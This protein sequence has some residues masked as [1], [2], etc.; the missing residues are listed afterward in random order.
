MAEQGGSAAA[1]QGDPGATDEGAG[2]GAEQG[3]GL[4]L[5]DLSGA[6]EELRPY[7]EQELK[8]YDGNVT[9]KFQEHADFRKR[10]EPYADVDFGDVQADELGELLQFRQVLQDPEQLQEWLGAVNE[11]LGLTPSSP[12]EWYALGEQNG[13]I[14]GEGNM[15]EPDE[16]PQW[17]QQLMDRVEALDGGFKQFQGQAEQQQTAAQQAEEFR[18]RLGELQIPEEDRAAVIQEARLFLEGEDPIGEA[19]QHVQTLRGTAEGDRV[20]QRLERNGDTEG[21]L[22]QGQVNSA[23]EQMQFGDPNLKA[24]ALARMKQS[25]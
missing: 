17:A 22:P 2:Q 16:M 1:A 3:V 25:P 19:W 15:E 5:Y 8:K 9:K 7:L 4:G 14:D 10:F 23:A 13:W 21:A 11:Q 6:P 20:E 12:E 24:A 18:N